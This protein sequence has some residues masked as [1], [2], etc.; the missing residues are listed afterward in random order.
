MAW[1]YI[2]WPQEVLHCGRSCP[3]PIGAVIVHIG[4]QY[5]MK[6]FLIN[7]I[8]SGNHIFDLLLSKS[9]LGL[10]IT[11]VAHNFSAASVLSKHRLSI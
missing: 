3:D 8:Y 4:T 2:S 1:L 10:L 6:L 5:W 11:S 9:Y 7:L